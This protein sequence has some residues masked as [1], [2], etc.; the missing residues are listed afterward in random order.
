MITESIKALLGEELTKQVEDAL[1]GKGKEGKDV[2]LVVGNDGSFVPADKY[3]AEKKGKAS[4]ET[5][6][7][8]AAEALKEV[9][10]SGDPAKI[11]DDVKAAQTKIND[12]SKEH[13]AELL[14]IQRSTA[15]KTALAGKVHDTDDIIKLLEMD[16]LEIDE[17]GSLK[18]NIDDLMK[19][20]KES[21]P[22][23]FIEEKQ[24]TTQQPPAI[25]GAQ[26]AGSGAGAAGGQGGVQPSSLTDAIKLALASQ[27]KQ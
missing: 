16:K 12:L 5:A 7:K 25:N 24:T 10:G 22:Y 26:P 20:I 11:A 19:P 4:A 13:K 8:S 15:V 2:D 14:K 18:S 9:G 27:Q 17:N 23:L 1:K 6:L 3:D 21:K